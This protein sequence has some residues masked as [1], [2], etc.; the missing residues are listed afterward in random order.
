MLNKYNIIRVEYNCITKCILAVITVEKTIVSPTMHFEGVVYVRKS[1]QNIFYY[2][3]IQIT[4]FRK[5][6]KWK[7]N[8]Q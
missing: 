3:L 1:Y 6:D 5:N 7:L 4:L 8:S 2:H